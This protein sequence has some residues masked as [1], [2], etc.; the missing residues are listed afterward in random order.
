MNKV[1]TRQQIANEMGISTKTLSRWIAKYRIQL[2]A[3]LLCEKYQQ[4]LHDIFGTK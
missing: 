2:P 4:L 1:K 3:G